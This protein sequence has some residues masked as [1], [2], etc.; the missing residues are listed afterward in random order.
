MLAHVV[1]LRDSGVLQPG[2]R[3][4]LAAET[5]QSFRIGM[6]ACQNHFQRHEPLQLVVPRQIDHSHSAAA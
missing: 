3:F 5:I 4:R 2:D 1:D 6:N